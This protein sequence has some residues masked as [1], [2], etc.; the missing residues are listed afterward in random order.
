MQGLFFASAFGFVP[1][2]KLRPG[3]AGLTNDMLRPLRRASIGRLNLSPSDAFRMLYK[4]APLRL[5][6]LRRRIYGGTRIEFSA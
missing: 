5:L 6:E 2:Q 1:R 4:I 3:A